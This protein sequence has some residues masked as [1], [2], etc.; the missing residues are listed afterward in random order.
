V[1]NVFFAGLEASPRSLEVFQ[2]GLGINIFKK[3]VS[4]K[5]IINMDSD[6]RENLD[7]DTDSINAMR[8]RNAGYNTWELMIQLLEVRLC[9]AELAEDLFGAGGGLDKCLVVGER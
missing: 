1:L 6:S 3:F 2:E 9:V 4:E 5:F 8:I 7:P